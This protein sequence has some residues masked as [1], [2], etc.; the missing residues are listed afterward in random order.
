M[1]LLYE[2]GIVVGAMV[3]KRRA[4]GVGETSRE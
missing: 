1:C 2:L 4:A 3:A